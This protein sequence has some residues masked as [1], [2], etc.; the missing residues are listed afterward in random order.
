MANIY[1]QFLEL[2]PT[3]K[4]YIG[5]ILSVNS[6]LKMSSV[7]LIDGR[8][9]SVTGEGSVGQTYLISNGRLVQQ[10]PELSVHNVVVY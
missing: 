4:Q 3:R 1:R 10:L 6:E 8:V 7:E 5:K 9:T 2:I